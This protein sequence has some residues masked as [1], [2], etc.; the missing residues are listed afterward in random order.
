MFNIY[1]HVEFVETFF[2]RSKEV[3]GSGGMSGW[4]SF[5]PVARNGHFRILNLMNP[6]N[7][8]PKSG[9]LIEFWSL[10]ILLAIMNLKLIHHF[11]QLRVSSISIVKIVNQKSL[12]NLSFCSFLRQWHFFSW[13]F[14]ITMEGNVWSCAVTLSWLLG[15]F[16]FIS[17]LGSG[18]RWS[19][20]FVRG[21]SF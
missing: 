21:D 10:K 14:K 20:W 19:D 16:A 4:D 13:S 6:D 2:C 11:T 1:H 5:L 18:W 15:L 9:N 8:Q 17:R 12:P 7:L 3:C